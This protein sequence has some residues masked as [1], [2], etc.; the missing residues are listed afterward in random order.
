MKF[1][2]KVHK[3]YLLKLNLKPGT[4]II[5]AIDVSTGHIIT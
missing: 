4:G 2:H 5:A 1:V 3:V